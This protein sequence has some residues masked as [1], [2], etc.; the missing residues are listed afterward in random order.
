MTVL[1]TPDINSLLCHCMKIKSDITSSIN[2][3]VVYRNLQCM[4]LVHP[5]S[6]AYHLAKP[7]FPDISTSNVQLHVKPFYCSRLKLLR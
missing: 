3:V 5:Q 1:R 6:P 7:N 4:V 2:G